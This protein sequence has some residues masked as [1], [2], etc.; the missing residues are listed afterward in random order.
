MSIQVYGARLVALDE[1]VSMWY[2]LI[3]LN[4]LNARFMS[5]AATERKN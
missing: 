3:P 4:A 2:T 5:N 1:S